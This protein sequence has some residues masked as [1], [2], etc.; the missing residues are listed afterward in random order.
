VSKHLLTKV[1]TFSE[2]NSWEI[3]HHNYLDNDYHVI[4]FP[5]KWAFEQIEAYADSVWGSAVIS[6]HELYHGRKKYASNVTGAYYS[7]RLAV[8][9]HLLS[10]KRQAAALIV[11]TIGKGYFAPL[12]V[13]QVRENVRQAMA[14][15]PLKFATE[16]LALDCL[17]NT[18]RLGPRAVLES[19]LLNEW[20]HQTTLFNFAKT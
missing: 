19:A 12:G 15:K 5:K 1:K 14:A 9:E 6:D 8:A 3:Y 13:W 20:R 4:L 18:S 10:R 11:R 17:T 2:I 16:Q 7:G